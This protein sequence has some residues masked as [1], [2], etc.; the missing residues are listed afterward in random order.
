MRPTLAGAQK[1]CAGMRH[2]SCLAILTK[3]SIG[4]PVPA[5]QPTTNTTPP[6]PSPGTT[7]WKK[8]KKQRREAWVRG[9]TVEPV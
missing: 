8:R 1:R 3:E 9:R 6:P 5:S 2:N 7:D 4:L